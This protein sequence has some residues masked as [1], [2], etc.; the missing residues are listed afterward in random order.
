MK[1]L[2]ATYRITDRSLR[3]RREFIGLTRDEVETL[4]QLKPWADRVAEAI[5]REF[6]DRQFSFP[7]TRAFFEEFARRRHIPLDVL[8]RRLETTQAEYFRQIFEEA[9][10]GGEFGI[11]YF[12]QR[13]RIGKVHNVINLPLKWYI[14]SY[15][16]YHDLVRKYLKRHFRLRPWLRERAERAIFTVFNYDIQAVTDAFFYD[17]LESVGFDLAAVPVEEPEQDL[18]DRYE[19]LK[20]AVKEA[21]ARTAQAAGELMDASAQMRR[22]TEQAG[23]ATAQ[24]AGA[25]QEVAQGAGRQTEVLNAV[26]SQVGQITQAID[27]IAKGAQE[28]A[29]AVEQVSAHM[30]RLAE[31]VRA[32]LENARE[33]THTGEEAARTA[34]A[35]FHTVGRALEMLQ[36]V[37]KMM[38]EAGE[39]IRR[40]EEYSGQIGAIVETIDDIAEQTNLLALNA[41]IEAARAGEQGRGFA[42][43]A[44]EVRKLAERSGR[45]TKEIARIIQEVQEGTRSAVQAM[46]DALN[47]TGEGAGQAEEARQALRAILDAAHRVRERVQGIVRS[48]EGMA[49]LSREVASALESISAVVQENSAAAEQVAASSG[50]ITGAMEELARVSQ[51]NA[52]AAQEVSAAAEEMSAQVE[53]V[54][55]LARDLQEMAGR[56][57]QSVSRFRVEGLAARPVRP[58]PAPSFGASPGRGALA[59]ASQDGSRA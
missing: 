19:A 35:G 3:L 41:A 22:A 32:V 8:R 54:A 28:Q 56:L 10:R 27:G 52:A 29:R 33:G 18:S 15:A 36:T 17:Y 12:E 14:G 23:Q 31:V 7:P 30:G 4:R 55:S 24:I 9:C 42:V 2:T 26:S 43:V 45:A 47:R 49:S 21:L 5:A 16:L 11:G 46:Q 58:E 39:R 44:D 53:S 40:L 37:Q 34:E 59:S 51:A 6:Y 1:S 13:L 25:V 38:A 50:Q 48:A 20:E 57:Q